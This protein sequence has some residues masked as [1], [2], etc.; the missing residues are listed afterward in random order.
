MY[1]KKLVSKIFSRGPVSIALA[2]VLSVLFVTGVVGAATTIS[3]NI[4][5]GGTLAVTGASTL[6]GAVTAGDT[7]AVT[8]VSTLTGG[9]IVGSSGTSM[10]KIL[11]GTCA[12]KNTGSYNVDAS[13]AASTTKPYECAITGV[14]SGDFVIA[15]LATSTKSGAA[16][17]LDYWNIIGA[18]ASTTAG[19]ITV[20]LYNNGAAAVPSVS[21]VGST[22]TYL[23]IHPN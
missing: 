7:L 13:H 20:L 15:Q 16:G 12:L 4:V 8:G 9:A 22:T 1:V 17:T 21:S 6:T 19:I 5:T 11:S 10:G 14:V 18:K 2:V 23:I 3:T